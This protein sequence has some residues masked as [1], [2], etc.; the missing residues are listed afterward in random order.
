MSE[1]YLHEHC[2]TKQL[3][4]IFSDF[5]ALEVTGGE[6][7]VRVYHYTGDLA[8]LNRDSELVPLIEDGTV[9]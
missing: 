9:G 2:T 7:K 8:A 3:S 1:I 4:S 6:P 5:Y